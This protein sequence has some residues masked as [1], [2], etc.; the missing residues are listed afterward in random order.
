MSP[1]LLR[2]LFVA[3][4]VWAI[5]VV[6]KAVIAV[7]SKQTYTFSMWDG[8]MIRAGKSLS[9]TGAIVKIVT[10]SALALS[11]LALI[12]GVLPLPGA[13]YVVIAIAIASITCDFALGERS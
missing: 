5:A 2:I 7:S 4:G 3:F 9:R 8:G 6:F 10:A 1:E 11:A 13:S 12:G